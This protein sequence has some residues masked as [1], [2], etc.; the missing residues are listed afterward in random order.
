MTRL[1]G[2]GHESCT[3]YRCTRGEKGVSAEDGACDLCGAGG[4]VLY[5]VPPYQR[6]EGGM[7][8]RLWRW[9]DGVR[10]DARPPL[11]LLGTLVHWYRR[12]ENL[13]KTG[14]SP[15]PE[16]VPQLSGCGTTPQTTAFCFLLL[17]SF[18]GK[19]QKKHRPFVCCSRQQRRVVCLG[20]DPPATVS[21]LAGR[22]P[23]A[24]RIGVREFE[25]GG[26][27]HAAGVRYLKKRMNI[28]TQ[29]LRSISPQPR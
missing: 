28:R 9:L 1:G 5:H 23:G 14:I 20:A 13:A 17:R 26:L 16:S 4:R 19:I 2:G 25:G 18:A 11:Y 15:V 10:G 27:V 3:A 6:G 8:W 24:F 29:I 22:S 12:I 7:G 21:R